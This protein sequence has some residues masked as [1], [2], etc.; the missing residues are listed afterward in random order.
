MDI[1]NCL[2]LLIKRALPN[3]KLINYNENDLNLYVKG[4]DKIVTN[5]N[6]SKFYNLKT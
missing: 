3:Q 6:K 4:T 5:K 2:Q 1:F